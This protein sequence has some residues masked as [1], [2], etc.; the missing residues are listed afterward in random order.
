MYEQLIL[1]AQSL[2]LQIGGPLDMRV[3]QLIR[4]QPRF[5]FTLGEVPGDAEQAAIISFNAG[6]NR[7]SCAISERDENVEQSEV[8]N[9]GPI[10]EKAVVEGQSIHVGGNL[11]ARPFEIVT[12]LTLQLHNALFSIPSDRKWYLARVQLERLLLD[13]DRERLRITLVKKSG[14]R[15]TRCEIASGNTAI[16]TIDFMLGSLG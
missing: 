15:L 11:D 16:G 8:Y 5:L 1:G 2:G 10:R 6:E 9:E 3:S 7:W 12:S 4:K 14:I 13:D